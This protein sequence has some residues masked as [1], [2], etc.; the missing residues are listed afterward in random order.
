MMCASVLQFEKVA[1]NTCDSR[2]VDVICDASNNI[3]FENI[4]CIIL[5]F[6]FF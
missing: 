1:D 4:F 2:I 5:F 3:I 6:Y